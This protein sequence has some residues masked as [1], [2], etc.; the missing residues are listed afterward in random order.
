MNPNKD[1][2]HG[3]ISSTGEITPGWQTCITYA[4]RIDPVP[5]DQWAKI[6]MTYDSK[7]IKVYINEKLGYDK[8][9]RYDKGIFNGA[10]YGADFTAGA[11]SV[12]NTMSNQ[13]I[14]LIDALAVYNIAL[15]KDEIL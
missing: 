12:C 3:H 5:V 15:K 4:S 13:F 9:F 2:V 1:L 7:N 8:K 11:N 14:G 10:D 6:A